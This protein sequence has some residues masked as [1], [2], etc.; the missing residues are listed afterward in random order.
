MVARAQRYIVEVAFCFILIFVLLG[1]ARQA[2]PATQTRTFGPQHR[3]LVFG[4]SLAL[5]SGA[6]N[7]ERGFTFLLY[8]EL[9]RKDP[10]AQI[11]S[12][13]VDGATVNDVLHDELARS[14]GDPA[15]DVWI[16]VGGNDVTHS[17]E[18]DRFAIEEAAVV[19]IARR[20]WP[21]AKVVVFGVPDV[22][23]SPLFFGGARLELR[24]L[25]DLDNRAA[26]DAAAQN[27]AVFVDLFAFGKRLNPLR[28]LSP[29]NFHPNDS[30]YE[31]MAVFAQRG[32]LGDN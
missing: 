13:A 31:A 17:T 26:R 32:V 1:C 20:R 30:G 11:T 5:G 23:R 18:A 7:P 15:T 22:S 10:D 27:Q 3:V 28:D 8:R 29:D 14:D 21:F 2:G 6:S 16:C 9:L 12:F 19:D 4:D 24:R 25:A